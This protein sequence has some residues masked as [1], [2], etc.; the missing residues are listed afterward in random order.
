MSHT[1]KSGFTLI[2]LLVVI[3]IIAILAAILFPVFAQAKGAAMSISSLSNQKQIGLAVVMYAGDYDDR[4]AETGW[5]GPCSSPTPNASGHYAVGDQFFSG[6]FSFPIASGPYIKN[7]D[8][9]KCPKDSDA[10]GFNKTGSY[11]YEAQLLAV[12]MPRSYEGMRNDVNAMRD[13]FP[14]SYAGNYLLS[15]VYTGE[16]GPRD[17][18]NAMKMPPM[19]AVAYPANT[20]YLA[21]VGT[22]TGADGTQ[23]AGWYITPGYG[24]NA[25][26]TGRWPKGKRHR[27]GRHW[28][29]V[30]GHAKYYK[31]PSFLRPDGTAKSGN[32]MIA[33]Y[34]RMGIYTY[35]EG[36][37]FT[38]N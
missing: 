37:V 36:P 38:N 6:V 18:R 12:N 29:F 28:T 1:N 20:F 13:S 25:A 2:E 11:C 34:E 26:G 9:F 31:D 33:D 24:N 27:D 30:D 3:A 19:T 23:F 17:A 4:M 15:Y 7:W 5:D 14:L 22:Q 8:I 21:D 35:K 16:A 10:G 32:E